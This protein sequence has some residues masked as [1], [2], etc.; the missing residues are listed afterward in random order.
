[1]KTFFANID[2]SLFEEPTI[3]FCSCRYRFLNV[4]ILAKP[5]GIVMNPPKQKTED[6]FFETIIEIT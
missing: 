4:T 1:M 2:N 5:T 6:M 3:E